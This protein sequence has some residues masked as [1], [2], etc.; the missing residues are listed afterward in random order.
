MS[1]PLHSC[2]TASWW[3]R[4]PHRTR[5]GCSSGRGCAG[6]VMVGLSRSPGRA[7]F[8]MATLALPPM[9]SNSTGEEDMVATLVSPLCPVPGQGQ[10]L[11]TWGCGWSRPPCGMCHSASATPASH[12]GG[13]L[14]GTWCWWNPSDAA[15]KSRCSSGSCWHCALPLFHAPALLWFLLPQCSRMWGCSIEPWL[16]AA[17]AAT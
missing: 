9:T 5:R 8:M 7:V 11:L 13:H 10:T 14:A 1:L 4:F 16:S 2:H 12:P 3:C 6:T 15:R 17:L